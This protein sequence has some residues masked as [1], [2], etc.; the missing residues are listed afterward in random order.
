[1]PGAEFTDAF[2]CDA[3]AQV[4]ERDYAMGD[5]AKRLGSVGRIAERVPQI[6]LRIANL[7]LRP[8]KEVQ[9]VDAQADEICC[10]KR[11]LGWLTSGWDI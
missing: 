1:M 11:H 6:Y 4:E 3:G 8:V 10:L 7:F 9:E 2:K 5:L